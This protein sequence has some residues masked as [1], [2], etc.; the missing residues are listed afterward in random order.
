[1]AKLSYRKIRKKSSKNSNIKVLRKYNYDLGFNSKVNISNS[2]LGF[3]SKLP[4]GK[5][6][7]FAH[8]FYN[9]T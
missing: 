6:R 7:Y 1:M 9:V 5:T 3:S 4:L 2:K 8:F